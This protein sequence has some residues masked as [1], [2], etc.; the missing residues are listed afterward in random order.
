MAAIDYSAGSRIVTEGSHVV[1]TR[2][3]WA[4]AWTLQPN[5]KCVECQWNAAPAMNSAVLRWDTGGVILP[6]DS[7]PTTITPWVGRGYFVRIVWTCDDASTL[8]WVGFIDAS[9]WPTEAFGH[10]SLVCYGLEQALAKT[11]MLDIVWRAAE[12]DVRRSAFPLTFNAPDGLR[13]EA[14]TEE[15]GEVYAFA[16][17]SEDAPKSWS[18]RE[19][20]RYLLKYHLP[21]DD[22]AVAAIPWAV[23]QIDQLPDWD[24]PYVET[25]NRTVW[26][27]LIELVS[28][29]L[30]LG[31]TV[32]S[33]GTSA[34]V[35]F[36]THLASTLTIGARTLAANPRQHTLVF[37]PDALTDARFSDV[38][39]GYDVVV[40][41]GA[42]RKS[43]CTLGFPALAAGQLL[44]DWDNATQE[45]AYNTGAQGEAGY[46]ALDDN[47][48][49]Q[50]ND[51]VRGQS[52]LSYVFRRFVLDPN[53]DFELG[54]EPEAVFPGN[55][56]P[57]SLR[58][59]DRLPIAE[60][61]AMW[62]GELSTDYF[63]RGGPGLPW[64]LTWKDPTET[65][66]RVDNAVLGQLS[67][68]FAGQS[69]PDFAVVP[70]VVGDRAIDLIVQGGPQH[71]IATT[72][73]GDTGVDVPGVLDYTE[74]QITLAIEED[75]F[76]EGVYPVTA[77][78]V[79]VVRR[80]CV[81][82]GEAY[83]Q[84]YVVPETVVAIGG[85]TGDVLKSD[86][87]VLVDDS[88][89]LA[90]LAEVIARS[91]VRTRKTVAWSSLRKISLIAVGDLITTAEGQTVD[92]PVVAIHM[93]APVS[94]NA[95]AG[96]SQQSFELYRGTQDPLGLLRRMG[97]TAPGSIYAS[98][99]TV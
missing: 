21:T 66:E 6:G 96:A 51:A 63:D 23:D 9:E 65:L 71:M 20:V 94:I 64:L 40:C 29:E 59:V 43:I 73:T 34:Y 76:C 72:F 8:Q 25:R 77:P 31:F 28:G 88:P 74:A 75:R 58:F 17:A 81:D 32:G 92:A 19:I 56:S 30:Q 46:D 87:G 39:G 41:R 57:R 97:G 37:M 24:S 83:Q 1:Y 67:K 11:P 61:T 78:D 98:R 5:L 68:L 89:K 42:R 49:A 84:V 60:L 45:V 2:V 7:T 85:V 14:V 95:P 82:M 33:D 16:S 35:R 13:S 69:I 22:Q 79:D 80:L 48:K 10:Q 50:K 91:V 38:G 93:R 54:D 62:D 70:H 12:D 15:D 53:W 44:A 47:E 36:F 52:F 26:D 99:G 3:A 90:A 27:V 55:D 86:G 4:D 18:T